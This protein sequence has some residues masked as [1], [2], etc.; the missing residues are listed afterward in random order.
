MQHQ[1]Y[2]DQPEEQQ[3]DYEGQPNY[4]TYSSCEYE[5]NGQ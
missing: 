1:R 4:V 2:Q 5:V 3:Q